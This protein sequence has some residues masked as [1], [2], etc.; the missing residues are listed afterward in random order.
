[1]SGC[2]LHQQLSLEFEDLHTALVVKLVKYGNDT[3][4]A[5]TG[6]LCMGNVYLCAYCVI[7]EWRRWKLHFLECRSTGL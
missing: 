4:I 6:R 2:A 5:I 1:M 3:I 7:R